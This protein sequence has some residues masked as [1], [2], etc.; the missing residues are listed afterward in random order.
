DYSSKNILIKQAGDDL[1][2]RLVDVNRMKFT[3][4]DRA[5]RTQSLSRLHLDEPD[6]KRIINGYVACGEIDEQ[7]FH[8]TLKNSREFDA[9]RQKITRLKYTLKRIIKRT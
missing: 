3:T 9:R 1:I 8:D 4:F 7:F 2:F 5:A 6:M